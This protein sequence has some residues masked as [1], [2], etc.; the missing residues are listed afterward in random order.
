MRAQGANAKLQGGFEAT[1]GQEAASAY[2]LHFSS[3]A[4]GD[5]IELEDSDLLGDG[6]DPADPDDGP[7]KNEPTFDVPVDPREFGFWL[8]LLLGDPATTGTGPYTHV[9]KSGAATLP[10]ATIDVQYTDLGEYYRQLGFTANTLAI[11]WATQGKVKATIAGYA[12]SESKQVAALDATPVALALQ[13]FSVRQGYVKVNGVYVG[14]LVGGKLNFSNGLDPVRTIRDD[15]RIEGADPGKVSLGGEIR[16]RVASGDALNTAAND[17]TFIQNLSFGHKI[18]NALSLD[19]TLHRVKLPKPKR[20]IQGPGGLEQT[21]AIKAAKD[22]V[23]ATAMTVT[24]VN[25]VADYT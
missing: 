22:A 16:V 4:G 8:C 21:Y 9:W 17:R 3:F 5:E 7:I 15:G 25:D 23:Q 13:R 19:F 18:S 14:N 1:Y 24:L 11:D 10:S 20:S 6:R 12:Q 2:N